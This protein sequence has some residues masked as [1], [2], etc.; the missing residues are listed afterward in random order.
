MTVECRS[1]EVSRR[2]GTRAG[3]RAAVRGAAR[4]P[5]GAGGVALPRG[6]LFGRVRLPARRCPRRRGVGVRHPGA[7]ARGGPRPGAARRLPGRDARAGA[8]RAPRVH[9]GRRVLRPAPGR[10]PAGRA[11]G[12]RAARHP[13]RGARRVLVRGRRDRPAGVAAARRRAGPGRRRPGPAAAGGGVPDRRARRARR[14]PALPGRGHGLDGLE[15]AGWLAG[16]DADGRAR[17]L[18]ALRAAAGGGRVV[19]RQRLSYAV[20]HA[21]S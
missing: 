10:R 13:P 12:A 20:A 18:H 5:R 17:T 9:P 2:A 16:V 4:R 7:A 11:E 6:R 21:S 15:Q 19:L 3:A 8:V 1:R 14:R